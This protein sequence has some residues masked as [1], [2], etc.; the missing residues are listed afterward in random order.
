MRR[1][2]YH[3]FIFVSITFVVIAVVNV[4]SLA[5]IASRRSC[6]RI[7]G[8]VAG[9]FGILSNLPQPS[10][11]LTDKNDALCQTGFFTNI[12]QYRCTEIGDISDE[13]IAQDLTTDQVASTDAL[14]SKL[15][16]NSNSSSSISTIIQ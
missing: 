11:A 5:L 14:M 3:F 2:I 6:C 7:I 9:A 16:V 1:S 12:M 13:G 10:I 15:N 4:D 8:G